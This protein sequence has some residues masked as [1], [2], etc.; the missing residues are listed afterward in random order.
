MKKQ[1]IY[2]GVVFIFA[3]NTFII[4]CGGKEE[5]STEK[6]TS[7]V[8]EENPATTETVMIDETTAATITGKI[9]F[10]GTP[11]KMKKIEM[12]AE[13][14]CKDMYPEGPFTQNVIVNEN[15]TLK[16]VFVYVKEG[17]ENLTFPTPEEEVILDQK[18]CRYY[19]HVFG[20]QPN[21]SIKI[22]NSDPVAH[23][24]HP[25][26]Q[27]NKPFNIGQPVQGMETIKKFSTSEV[28][29][30]VGCDIH[31]W[32][33]AYIA[34][35]DHPYFITTGDEGTFE[36]KPLPPG[37]YVIE[38]W[39]EEYG[40]QTQTVTVGESEAKNITFTFKPTT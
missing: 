23:N 10:S 34:I 14:S 5:A 9:S 3:I 8:G 28:M 40:S 20:I 7:T 18:G 12:A 4:G 27:N 21:Q 38:A 39:H 11:P 30:P 29:I 19:P 17:L 26:P 37:N 33:S 25:R 32:M 35:V 1:I 6:S 13:M 16:N 24:I 15:G 36:L 22:R 31:I 2:T